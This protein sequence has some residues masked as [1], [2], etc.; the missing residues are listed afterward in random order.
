MSD[1]ASLRFRVKTSTVVVFAVLIVLILSLVIVLNR[2]TTK[3]LRELSE[4]AQR[5]GRGEREARAEI[6][7]RDAI[8]ALGRSIN[9]MAD[10]IEASFREVEKSQG[11]LRASKEA[12]SVQNDQLAVAFSRQAKFGEY[13]VGLA[14]ID[15]N[16]LAN[17]ALEHIVA[18]AGAQ[19]GAFFLLEEGGQSLV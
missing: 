6:A 12:L 3:R 13:L 4:V 8:G 11:E 18:A 17:K 2:R 5:I 19:V 14:S 16:T 9:M 1:A 10:R 7:D 15:I